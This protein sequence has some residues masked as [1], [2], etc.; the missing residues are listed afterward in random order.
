MRQAW[1]VAVRMAVVINNCRLCESTAMSTTGIMVVY[2][3]LT[4]TGSSMWMARMAGMERMTGVTMS[5]ERM[6]GVTMS[7]KTMT[8]ASYCQSKTSS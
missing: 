2:E 8:V 4:A 7:M 6:V 5:M 1:V 3:C